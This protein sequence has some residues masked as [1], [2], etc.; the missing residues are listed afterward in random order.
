MKKLLLSSA[1]LSAVI[2]PAAASAQPAPQPPTVVVSYA[3][4]DLGVPSGRATL[5]HRLAAAIRKVCPQ[6]FDGGQ[7]DEVLART[8]CVRTAT[9]Q[10]HAQASLVIARARGGQSVL[11]AR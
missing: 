10:G 2:S 8:R 9:A 5:E 11:A 1:I 6:R 3:D 4:L 7:V